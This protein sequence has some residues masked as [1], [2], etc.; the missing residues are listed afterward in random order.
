MDTVNIL[1]ANCD[2]ARAVGNCVFAWYKIQGDYGPVA[3]PDQRSERD[4]RIL[5][6]KVP[7]AALP[8]LTNNGIRFEPYD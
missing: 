7:K 4:G 8:L 2:D 5:V 1:V 6:L 3:M